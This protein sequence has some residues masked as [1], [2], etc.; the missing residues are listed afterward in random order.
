MLSG[1]GPTIQLMEHGIPV[2]QDAIG[3][4]ENLQD[5]IASGGLT[6]LIQNPLSEESLSFVFPKIL[7]ADT[8]RDFVY[9]HD[10]ALYSMPAS[11][12]MAFINTKYQDPNEDWPDVQ[13][14]LSSYSDNSDGGIFGRRGGHISFQY[15]SD[16]Y[17]PIIYRDAFMIIPLLMRPLSRGRLWLRSADPAEHPNINA[18]YFDHPHD[19]EVL[20]SNKQYMCP[21]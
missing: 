13:F 14:F 3:V 2:I 5:H 1:V 18:N 8:I 16:V 17:E 19:L 12:V 10:G 6:Y 4:G 7:N 15:Y 20:V 21:T 9:R 11:E